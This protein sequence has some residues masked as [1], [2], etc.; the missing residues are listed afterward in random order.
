MADSLNLRYNE[1]CLK[2]SDINE[3][4]PTL[5][6]YAARCRVVAELGVR[7]C[8][9]SWSFLKGLTYQKE[10][11]PKMIG[12][13]LEW[14]DNIKQVQKAAEENGIEYRFIRGDSAKVDL[15]KVDLLFIDTWHVYGHLK[16]E[17]A[18]HHAQVRSYIILHDTTVDAELGESLRERMDI[19][20][21]ARE[22]GYPIEEIKRGLW[23]AVTEFLM[24]HPEWH[25]LKRYTH[26]NGLTILEKD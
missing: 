20:R 2:T 12:V 22:S 15:P 14:H 23:P 3:H 19:E 7:S 17:L 10:C 4:L 16:R 9:S 8:V 13:D 26:N 18:K 1:V 6:K 24:E 21:Q 25:L 11:Q 5:R